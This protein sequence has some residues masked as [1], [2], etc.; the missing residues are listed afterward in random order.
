MTALV[1]A[2]MLKL[3]TTR[4][5][6]WLLLA[7]LL[8]E[9][10]MVAFSIPKRGT[11]D[12]L[13]PLD[14]PGLLAATLGTGLLISQVVVTVFGVMAFTQE[15]RYGSITST[16][17]IEPRRSRIMF[18]KLV[19][20]TLVSAVVVLATLVAV[21]PP[22]AVIIG[23]RGGEIAV[24]PQFW[25]VLGAGFVVLAASAAI[26]V[27]IGALIRHQI[28]AVVGVLVWMTVVEHVVIPAL[29]AWGRWMP[30]GA[31]W[32]VMQQGVANG[33]DDALPAAVGGL[34]LLGY[35][36]VLVSLAVVVTPKRDVV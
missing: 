4:T 6:G 35:A 32:S 14:D 28:T 18:A 2:E 7:T 5:T 13:V 17:L 16:Y 9:G 8:V 34:V 21:V 30:G 36:A 20:A 3:R 24:G 25:Q 26:G 1:L 22:S 10:L 19:G 12:A 33:L 27:A 23:S 15:F 29:P 31:T 11:P